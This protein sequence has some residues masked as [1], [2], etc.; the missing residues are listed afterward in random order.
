[1]VTDDAK[2]I[3]DERITVVD[4][5]YIRRGFV[6]EHGA[7]SKIRLDVAIVARHMGDDPLG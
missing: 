1:M 3:D 7:T 5:L 2:Q 4:R 6:E